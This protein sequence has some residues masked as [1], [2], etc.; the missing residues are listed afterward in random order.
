MQKYLELYNNQLSELKDSGYKKQLLIYG[1]EVA[2]NIFKKSIFNLISDISITEEEVRYKLHEADVNLRTSRTVPV[3]VQLPYDLGVFEEIIYKQPPN[4]EKVKEAINKATLKLNY[5][6]MNLI[7]SETI[8]CVS[9]LTKEQVMSKMNVQRVLIIG[10]NILPLA[11]EL[12]H[13]QDANDLTL[14]GQNTHGDFIYHSR[15][16]PEKTVISIDLNKE[17]LI[18][19]KVKNPLTIISN[20]YVHKA[21]I[22]IKNPDVVKRYVF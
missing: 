21:S 19:Y 1:E 13:Q 10:N 18:D 4:I 14:L 17:K 8:P 2:K 9:T 7:L 6:F 20:Q 16:V 5:H 22:S 11:T 15:R 3:V 12:T